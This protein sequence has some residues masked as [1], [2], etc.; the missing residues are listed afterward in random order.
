LVTNEQAV[1]WLSVVI[2]LMLSFLLDQVAAASIAA[3]VAVYLVYDYRS[4]GPMSDRR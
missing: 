2:L 3:M 1:L 4:D